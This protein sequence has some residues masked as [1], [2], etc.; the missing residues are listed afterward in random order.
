MVS[1]TDGAE[2]PL[3]ALRDTPHETHVRCHPCD[4]GIVRYLLSHVDRF[5]CEL[6]VDAA[7]PPGELALTARFPAVAVA[8]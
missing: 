4:E 5:D 8:G 3:R 7:V 2:A 1:M 6:A